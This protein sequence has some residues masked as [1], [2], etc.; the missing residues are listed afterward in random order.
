MSFNDQLREA[1]IKLATGEK[2]VIEIPQKL[3]DNEMGN[4]KDKLAYIRTIMGRV[5]EVEAVGRISVKRGEITDPNHDYFGAAIVEAR[6][7]TGTKKKVLGKKDIE[8]LVAKAE[9]KAAKK[10]LKLSPNLANYTPDEYATLAKVVADFHQII[11]ESFEI[12]EGE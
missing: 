12:V 2:E 1:A 3:V 9:Q 8:S 5:K 6:L 7:V 11:R 4:I 10:M